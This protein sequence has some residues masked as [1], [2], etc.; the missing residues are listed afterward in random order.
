MRAATVGN[1]LK[2]MIVG[3][4][5]GG[6]C[7]AQGLK[8][9][10][11][12]V[13][14]FER[15]YSPTDRL[16]GYRL[17]VNETGRRALKECL[18]DS[19]FDKLIANCANP[20]RAVTFLDHRLNRLLNV[21]F[22]PD[23]RNDLPVSR[24]SLRGI[25]LEGLDEIVRFCKKFI[26]FEEAPS[27]AVTARF[28]DR[29]IATGD[30][31]IGAD[32]ASSRVRRQLLPHAERVET[33]ILAVSGKIAMTEAVRRATPQAF[34][35][36]PTLVLGPKG[37]FMFGSAV[38]YGNSDDDARGELEPP[39]TR[40]A[41]ELPSD[42]EQYVMWGFSAPREA[43]AMPADFEAL[44]AEDL[45]SRVLALTTDWAGALRH[46][47][48]AA[49]PA[50]VTAF[51][52]KTSVPIP[53]WHTRRVTLL[54]DALHNMT[55][56]RGIGANTALRDAAALRQ[57]LRAVDRGESDLIPALATYER[58]MVD[59]GFAAVRDSLRNM[60]RF[61]AQGRVQRALTKCFFRTID[62]VPPLKA[63]FLSR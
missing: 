19:L 52:V 44:G 27:G 60:E 51:L 16:Q 12:A 13:E 45:K 22:G 42:R 35:R 55:P 4:G 50:T 56:Y 15:D 1:G 25:L 8:A 2:V 47:V 29:S 54:G 49:Q 39:S 32:G 24:I 33:G 20:S 48:E 57:A 18:P 7:L 31:L 40:A 43:F 59:Y 17:G 21:D 14:V 10:G 5:T 26:A 11:I 30:V 3:A 36:G 23:G 37:C 62:A 46:L 28:D 38:E 63:A 61:H 58:E 53:P 41:A 6:L 34:L 9:D